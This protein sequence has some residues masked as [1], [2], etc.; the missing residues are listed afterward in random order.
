M[1][2]DHAVMLVTEEDTYTWVGGDH[3]YDVFGSFC[4]V[5]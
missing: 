1:S 2:D 5:P 3:C 4:F